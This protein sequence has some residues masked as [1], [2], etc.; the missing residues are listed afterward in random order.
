MRRDVNVRLVDRFLWDA[1]NK[2]EVRLGHRRSENCGLNQCLLR[3]LYVVGIVIVI[4]KNLGRV[5]EM[6][7][8]MRDRPVVFAVIAAFAIVVMVMRVSAV[9]MMIDNVAMR[10]GA[11]CELKY[12]GY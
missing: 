12:A 6:R 5:T 2:G 11:V 8:E 1:L 9:M 4:G 7:K 3:R 10:N